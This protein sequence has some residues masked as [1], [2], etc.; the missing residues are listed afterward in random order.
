MFNKQGY[1]NTMQ[2]FRLNAFASARI[3]TKILK[4]IKKTRKTEK[5]SK[6]RLN[7]RFF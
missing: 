4:S 1:Q 7:A 5:N 6:H 3:C 2:G